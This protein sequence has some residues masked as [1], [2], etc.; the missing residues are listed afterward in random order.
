MKLYAT[1]TSER[2]SK[3]QGGND[4]IDIIITDEK[5]NVI[6]TLFICPDIEGHI[7]VSDGFGFLLKKHGGGYEI[8]KQDSL[9]IKTDTIKASRERKQTKGNK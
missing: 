5:Q 6:K 2:A 7:I 1:T 3:G 4:Y 8:D 9:L